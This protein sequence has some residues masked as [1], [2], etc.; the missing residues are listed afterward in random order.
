MNMECLKTSS[1]HKTYD[2]KLVDSIFFD[3]VD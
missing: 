1:N 3:V 2:L